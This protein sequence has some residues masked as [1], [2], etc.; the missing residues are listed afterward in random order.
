MER[1]EAQKLQPYYLRNFLFQALEQLGGSLEEREKDRYEVKH[2]PPDVR[3]QAARDGGRRHV[4]QK[5]NRITFDRQLIRFLDRPKA[6]L[7]H[8][9]HALMAAT[10]DIILQENDSYLRQGTVL[11]DTGDGGTEPRLLYLIDHS[12]REGGD[13]RRDASRRIHMVEISA[14]GSLTR[15]GVAPYLDYQALQPED[16]RVLDGVLGKDWLRTDVEARALNYATETFVPEHLKEVKD[17]RLQYVEK[18]RKAVQERLDT[19]IQHW[20]RKAKE[21]KHLVAAGK[22]P[23]VQLIT[24]RRKVEDLGARLKDRMR[25][26]DQQAQLSSSPPKLLAACLVIPQGLIDQCHGR[27]PEQGTDPLAK[28]RIELLAMNAVVEAEA[29]QGNTTEDV[30]RENCGWDI[31]SRTP[32]GQTRHIEVKG[33]HGEATTVTV[34]HNE[35]LTAFNQGDKFILAIVLVREDDSVDGP[36]YVRTP[37]EK[38]PEPGM[39]SVNMTLKHFLE[40]AVAPADY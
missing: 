19:E 18:S 33:R 6:D 4:L 22:Q 12:I 39:A 20:S 3:S 28:K 26:L 9:G 8:P 2:V 5:Y 25:D 35:V 21:Y 30:S 27:T 24:A 34:S 14:E 23:E 11:V 1:A 40:R 29:A 17:R 10:L 31:T 15:P 38:E 36:Y 13:A 32:S 37:F 16:R 7:M